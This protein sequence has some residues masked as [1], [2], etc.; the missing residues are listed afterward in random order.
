MRRINQ[1]LTQNTELTKETEAGMFGL[2]RR[3]WRVVVCLIIVTLLSAE[4]AIEADYSWVAGSSMGTNQGIHSSGPGSQT[5][6]VGGDCCGN[7][8]VKW[9]CGHPWISFDDDSGGY[10]FHVSQT[11]PGDANSVLWMQYDGNVVLYSGAG[12]K[13]WATNTD[14]NPGAYLRLQDDTNLVVYSSGGFPLWSVF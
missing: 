12:N 2:P 5:L 8:Y 4:H 11:F 13:L 14:G 9:C 7:Y 3:R 1:R 10:G 6:V